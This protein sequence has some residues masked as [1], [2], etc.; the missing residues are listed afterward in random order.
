MNNPIYDPERY[1]H[2]ENFWPIWKDQ[3]S[4]NIDEL[5]YYKKNE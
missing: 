3:E 4:I 2:P 1:Y 5:P